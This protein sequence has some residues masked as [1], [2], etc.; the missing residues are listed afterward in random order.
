MRDARSRRIRSSRGAMHPGFA[1]CARAIRDPA[2]EIEHVEKFFVPAWTE[3]LRSQSRTAPNHLPELRLRSHELEEHEIHDFMHVDARIEHTDRHRDM[4]RLRGTGKIIDQRL[5]IVG[6]EVDDARKAAG[7]AREFASKRSTM[8]FAWSWFS[9]TRS[10]CRDDRQKP[11]SA[12]RASAVREPCR[13]CP[14]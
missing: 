1:A 13:Q 11:L 2:A 8:N 10:S 12:R 4:R 6:L 3:Q 14:C 5:R 9:R 7:I